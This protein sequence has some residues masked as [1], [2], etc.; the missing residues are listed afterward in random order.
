MGFQRKRSIHF[1]NIFVLLEATL[2]LLLMLLVS[3]LANASEI[4]LRRF[5]TKDL[6]KSYVLR[7]LKIL[8]F[9]NVTSLTFF[10]F[11]FFLQG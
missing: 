2:C 6:F 7:S 4:F 10:V 11:H 9:E 1:R 8:A 3:K 5:N